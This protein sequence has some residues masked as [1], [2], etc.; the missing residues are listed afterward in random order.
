MTSSV[1]IG[2]E[3]FLR[4][5]CT[6]CSSVPCLHVFV[7]LQTDELVKNANNCTTF[8]SDNLRCAEAYSLIS[9]GLCIPLTVRNSVF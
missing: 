2:P 9:Q 1:H 3:I 8:S 5:I 7:H 6:L 4:R